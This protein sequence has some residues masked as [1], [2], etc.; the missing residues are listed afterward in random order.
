MTDR[1]EDFGNVQQRAAARD[2]DHPGGARVV[3]MRL[4]AAQVD[5]IVKDWFLHSAKLSSGAS[6][7]V[8]CAA[9]PEYEVR[10]SYEPPPKSGK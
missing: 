4:Q 2:Q 10:V 6:V 5:Q 8:Y 3:T 9:S 7:T 1:E